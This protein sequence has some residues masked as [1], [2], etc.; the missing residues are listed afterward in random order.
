MRSLSKK[1][2]KVIEENLLALMELPSSLMELTRI[3]ARLM[4]QSALEEE[5]TAYLE[6]DCYERKKGCIGSRNGN[7][8]GQ[9]L[10]YLLQHK[11]K[12]TMSDPN[13]C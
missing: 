4:L 2:K 7:L 10:I 1:S 6:R 5:V 9:T 8:W 13:V 3:G 11:S 12:L